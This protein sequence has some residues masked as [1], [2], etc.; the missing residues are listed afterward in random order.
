MRAA[1]FSTYWETAEA[2]L[3][4][5]YSAMLPPTEA[6]ESSML[7]DIRSGAR[8]EIDALNGA[9]VALARKDSIPVPVNGLMCTMIRF[10]ESRSGN[11]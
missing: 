2:F 8:T 6:H 3:E 5:F 10:L 11:R 7:Q 4:A 9:V 1:G